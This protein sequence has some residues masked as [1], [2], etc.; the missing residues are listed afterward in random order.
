MIVSTGKRNTFFVRSL[1]I[2]Y[3]LCVVINEYITDELNE[4]GKLRNN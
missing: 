4:A 2:M 1:I 3:K